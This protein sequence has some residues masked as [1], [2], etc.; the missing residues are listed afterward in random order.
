MEKYFLNIKSPWVFDQPE[1]TEAITNKTIINDGAPILHVYHDI[2][3]HGWHFLGIEDVDDNDIVLITMEEIV[4][5][6]PSVE[7]V[8]HIEPGWH[9]WRSEIGDEW[10][11]AEY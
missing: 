8:A 2:N 6:D 3:N 5:L 4:E 7:E 1:D 11:F 10:I 9:A